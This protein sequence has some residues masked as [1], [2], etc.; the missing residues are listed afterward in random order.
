MKIPDISDETRVD[1]IG[2]VSY[3]LRNMKITSFRL[4]DASIS[5]V[6]DTQ[7]KAS[8]VNA[9]L[10]MH[11]DWK[12]HNHGF[13]RISDDGSVD[14]KAFSIT[15]SIVLQFGYLNG[16][17]SISTTKSDCNFNI[18]S[19]DV[20]FHGGASWLYNLFK[21]SVRDQIQDQ[22]NK[23]MCNDEIIKEVNGKLTE[24]VTVFKQFCYYF[25]VIISIIIAITIAIILCGVGNRSGAIA[26]PKDPGQLGARSVMPKIDKLKKKINTQLF[27]RKKNGQQTPQ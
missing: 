12:Y 5:A 25:I 19:L 21:G 22:L 14:V 1:V 17:F 3:K 20:D 10:S 8:I 2:K 11:G 18:G 24:V 27:K 23:K 16:D 9:R 15:L 26:N 4:P 7:L 13:I 6:S